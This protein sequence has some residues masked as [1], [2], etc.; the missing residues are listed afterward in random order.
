MVTGI[1]IPHETHLALQKVEF[2]NLT[3]YQ[4]AVG[5]YIETVK[6][7]G[8]PLVIVADE[9][10]KVKQ[11][12]INRRATCL[13]WLLNP[14]GLGG[15]FLVGDVVILGARR[16]GDMN[17]VPAELAELLL[18]STRFQVQVRLSRG[19]DTWVPI[20]EPVDDFFEATIRALKLMEVWSPPEEVKVIAVK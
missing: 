8:H 15:D 20:G 13:W 2:Q 12:P 6:M 3:D 11:L 18:E 4:T 17:D 5:G 1:V 9:D 19:F 16:H 14:S 7:N 10:G